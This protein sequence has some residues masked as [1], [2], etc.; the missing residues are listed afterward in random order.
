ML[1]EAIV[2]TNALSDAAALSV[3][4][5]LDIP[6]VAWPNPSAG[7]NC[8]PQ[9]VSPYVAAGTPPASVTPGGAAATPAAPGASELPAV[10]DVWATP[11]NLSRSGSASRPVVTIDSRGN[12]YAAWWDQFD[13]ATY[14]VNQPGQGWS[15]RMMVPILYGATPLPSST[16]PV[17]PASWR[18]LADE[19]GTLHALWLDTTGH[20]LHASN[21]SPTSSAAWSVP[22]T[23]ASQVLVWSAQV[24][25]NNLHVAYVQSDQDGALPP[26]IYYRRLAGAAWGQPQELANSPYF[27]SLPAKAAYL[28]LAVN[29]AG[30]VDVAWDDPQSLSSQFGRSTDDGQTFGGRVA[31]SIA[32]PRIDAQAHHLSLLPVHGGFLRQWEFGP[33]CSLYQQQLSGLDG[34]WSAPVRVLEQLPGCLVDGQPYPLA[35]GRLVLW[36]TVDDSASAE[37]LVLWNGNRWSQSLRADFSFVNPPTIARPAYAV[38]KRPWRAN[39]SSCWDAMTAAMCGSPPAN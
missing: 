25:G 33:G 7:P 11:V 8:Q 36:A 37:N 18:L 19:S 17:P 16:N 29:D 6:S 27:R 20:L 22:D 32:D 26:G 14:M 21:A 28:D 10:V 35:D 24:D 1:P 31:L 13:G 38:C 3:G 5:S 9:F 4:Q 23:L 30:E 39:K 2:T 15:P 34:S 12:F